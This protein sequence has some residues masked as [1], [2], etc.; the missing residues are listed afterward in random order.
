M[1]VRELE[2]VEYLN[3]LDAGL[4]YGNRAAQ[5]GA[6]VMWSRGQGPHKSPSRHN[7]WLP[8]VAGRLSGCPRTG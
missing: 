2:S 3:P 5:S 6:L 8:F 1:S 7:F 4:R